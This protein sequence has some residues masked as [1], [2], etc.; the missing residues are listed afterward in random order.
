MAMKIK[1]VLQHFYSKSD[2]YGN[3]YHY[4]KITNTN[5]GRSL[6]WTSPDSSNAYA[7][8]RRSKL[9][10]DH[11]AIMETEAKEMP[12]KEFNRRVKALEKY[13]NLL[14]DHCKDAHI[15]KA[16]NQLSRKN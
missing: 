2:I 4:H 16:I 14:H 15:V 13:D 3:R 5:T 6:Y 11:S 1:L 8:A 7:Q 9:G 10:T 12:I